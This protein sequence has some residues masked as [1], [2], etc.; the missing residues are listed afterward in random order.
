VRVERSIL[1]VLAALLWAQAIPA[2]AAE[3]LATARQA[4]IQASRAYEDQ[5][6]D[7]AVAGY[8]RA[9]DLG[10][11]DAI[12][13]YDLANAYYKSG[14][15]G[16]AILWYERAR[17]LAPRDRAI[18]H[19]LA[20]AHS[21]MQDREISSHVL[22]V[23]LRPVIWVRDLLSLDEWSRLL[24][25]LFLLVVAY[26]VWRQWSDSIPGVVRKLVPVAGGL[27]I[28]AAAMTFQL[29]RAQYWQDSMV[30]VVEES[31]VH[32]G[33]GSGYD[34]TFRVHSGLVV[35]VDERREGWVRIDLGGELVGWLPVDAAEAL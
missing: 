21:Q 24:V 1:C 17:R 27:L 28:V 18:R 8:T 23:M 5:D 35:P 29:Y 19:N 16:R 30:V 32:S 7:S 34:V 20:Q 11:D 6:Y 25:G 2:T 22:P 4:A 12:L 13:R 33:P 9:I 26:G 3:D 10:L 15:L 31:D 14:D